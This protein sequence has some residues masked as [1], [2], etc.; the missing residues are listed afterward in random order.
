MAYNADFRSAA[1]LT[2]VARNRYNQFNALMPLSNYF[3]TVTTQTMDYEFDRRV[4]GFTDQA[5]YREFSATNALGL[6]RPM[7]TIRGKIPPIGRDYRFSE[8]AR[9]QLMQ[10]DQRDSATAEKLDSFAE[11]GAEAITRRL[12][13]ARI[14][15]VISGKVSLAENNVYATV[16]FGRDASLTKTL[17]GNARWSQANSDPVKNIEDW[18][19][20]A[21]KLTGVVP[22]SLLLSHDVYETLR[23]N[24]AIRNGVFAGMAS[25]GARTSRD[26]LEAFLAAEAG[27]L[28]VT[29]MS[30]AYASAELD[31]G[32]PWPDGYAVLL[33]APG[34]ALGSTQFGIDAHAVQSQFGIS[35]GQRAGIFANAYD[36][37][38][39]VPDLWVGV[40][41]IAIPVMPG[42]NTVV[43]GKVL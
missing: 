26:Q 33:A 17:T 24:Q 10:S 42:V 43:G 15:A 29:D 4:V 6:E 1:Q 22:V 36:R 27:L 2:A 38:D 8:Y 11:L 31:M 14:E 30:R 35:A 16:D 19:E 21:R 5:E 37:A 34:P 13:R 3:P 20:E 41:A 7:A 28:Y 12:E 9:V 23:T 39:N 32:T 25:V 40:N 18:I